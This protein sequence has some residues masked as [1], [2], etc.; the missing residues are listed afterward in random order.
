MAD[1][2]VTAVDN[3]TKTA[4]AAA[5]AQTLKGV[6]FFEKNPKAIAISCAILGAVA[7]IAVQ[8]FI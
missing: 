7:V 3:A 1:P 8:H 4:E 6:S 2:I 5:G